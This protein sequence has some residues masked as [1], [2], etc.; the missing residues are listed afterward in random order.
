LQGLQENNHYLAYFSLD[1]KVQ[2]TTFNLPYFSLDF[3]HVKKQEHHYK[4][5]ND[6][7]SSCTLV[8]LVILHGPPSFNLVSQKNLEISKNA[9][10]VQLTHM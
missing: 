5:C 3:D 4:A 8:T 9:M 7:C 6:A 1:F 2:L 10:E